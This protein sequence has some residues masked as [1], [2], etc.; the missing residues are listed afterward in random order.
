MDHFVLFNCKT[1]N[2]LHKSTALRIKIALHRKTPKRC[3][4]L[5]PQCT[6][7]RWYQNLRHFWEREP[8]FSKYFTVK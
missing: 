3:N 5:I 7:G 4:L 6:N 1:R 2:K 8:L